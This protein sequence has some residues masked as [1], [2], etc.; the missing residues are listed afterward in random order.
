MRHLTSSLRSLLGWAGLAL[1]ALGGAE[2]VRAPSGWALAVAVTGAGLALAGL[3]TPRPWVARLLQALTVGT[4]LVAGRTELRRARIA[5][6]WPANEARILGAVRA[7]LTRALDGQVVRLRALAERTARGSPATLERA[8]AG[9]EDLLPRAEPEVALAVLDSLG[10]PAVWAGPHRLAPG[11]GTEAVAVRNDGWYTVL[12]VRHPAPS[13]QTAVATALLQADPAVPGD[14]AALFR[15]IAARHGV[16]IGVDVAAA[17]PGAQVRWPHD[18]PVISFGVVTEGPGP[19]ARHLLMRARPLVA[20]TV[21]VM[22]AVAALGAPGL[23]AR[24]GFLLG[25]LVLAVRAPIGPALGAE[26]SFSPAA[27][28]SPLL[29][30]LSGSAGHLALAG[31]L[32]VVAA[33]WLAGRRLPASAG[34]AALGVVVLAAVP[35]V[36]REFG[37]GIT[38]PSRGVPL[39][40][41]WSWHL[42]LLLITAALLLAG[43]TLLRARLPAMTRRW[44]AVL[45][46]LAGGVAAVVGLAAFTAR[47]GWPAWYTLVWAPALLLAVWPMPRVANL[48]AIATVSATGASLMAWGA[49]MAGRTDVAIRDLEGLGPALDPL[50]EPLLAEFGATLAGAGRPEGPTGLY[51]QWR[52]GG[53]AAQGY[54]T[55]LTSWTLA[56][57]ATGDLVL[58]QLT[59]PDSVLRALAVSTEA[60]G[61]PT[62]RRVEAMPGMHYLLAVRLPDEA[63]VTVAVGPRTALVDPA[64]LGRVLVTGPERTEL[65]T[66]SFAPRR[67]GQPAGPEGRWT[68]EGWTLRHWRTVPFDQGPREVHALI[69][70]GKPSWLVVRGALLVAV[71]VGL[72]ALLWLVAAVVLGRGPPAVDWRLFARSYQ[73]RVALAL[74]GFCVVPA[75]LLVG[76]SLTQLTGEARQT[77]TLV[78][79]RILRDA[80]PAGGFPREGPPLVRALDD[81]RDRVDADLALYRDGRRIATSE[82]VLEELGVFPPLLDARAYHAIHLDGD[83][84]AAPAD[85]GPGQWP[86]RA[87]YAALRADGGRGVTVLG[88]VAPATDRILRERLLDLAFL[89]VLAALL[90]SLAAVVGARLAA[91]ALARPVRDLREAALAF[92]AGDDP[93]LAGRTAPPEF[94]PVFDA[95]GRMAA[96]VRAGQTA[97]EAARRRTDA[98]LATVATG[99]VAVDQAGTILLANRR[100]REALAR[101]L[102]VGTPLA[103]AAEGPWRALGREV[104]RRLSEEVDPDAE[105]EV[106]ADAR[107]YAIQFA[108]LGRDPGGLVLAVQD[109]TETTR[110]ARVLAWAEVANQVAHA[111]K[112]PLTPLRLGV[113]HMQ[114]VRTTRPDQLG[115]TVDETGDRVLAEIERLDAIARAFSR[116]AA[117]VDPGRPTEPVDLAEVAG[118]VAALYRMAPDLSVSVALA[119]RTVWPANRDEVKEV[120]FNLLENARNAGARSITLRGGGAYVEVVDDGAGIPA[121]L[122]AR[123]FEPRFSTTSSGSGLGLAI[124]RRLVEG[125]GGQVTIRSDEGRGTTVALQGPGETPA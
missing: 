20:G 69:P 52:A 16:R 30:A 87:A 116:F 58:D 49:A 103:G 2:W 84:A 14:P 63:V 77:R 11:P 119:G 75:A 45:A 18:R 123:V 65:Y 53:L 31:I 109:V 106:E 35:Y 55:R 110:A 92:G 8:F 38:P 102:E 105:L 6:D 29:G 122:L 78:L 74:A 44:P 25:L 98:V 83:L 85:G 80:A 26:L 21:V 111:I 89:L 76:L 71:D 115:R 67:A 36:L 47:P 88:T 59:V 62:V 100:A 9:L 72:L 99:V 81:Q 57:E 117:P 66:L 4:V 93:D 112:N 96:D 42:A 51:R 56:G 54:P 23:W 70:L 94:E 17:T 90:G 41:W 68:R 91:R 15:P 5:S 124:V 95:F 79:Q 37:R 39:G 61:V 13:G 28:F 48:V 43:A 22:L 1:A 34:L 82:P 24:L 97:L 108:P 86:V 12:E 32:A 19:A 50:V 3:R 120:L 118:E 60:V 73:A 10:E 114:R 7:D 107:R 101:P 113:Q 104:T 125:W 27:Y 46:V 33:A 40:L 64:P 121:H